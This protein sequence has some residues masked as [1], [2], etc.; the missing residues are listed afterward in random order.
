MCAQ[1]ARLMPQAQSIASRAGS[2]QERAPVG[3]V[4]WCN[5]SDRGTLGN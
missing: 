2:N 5:F 4:K 1:D 3:A